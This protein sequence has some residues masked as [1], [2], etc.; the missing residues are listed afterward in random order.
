MGN[1]SRYSIGWCVL[2]RAVPDDGL[3]DVLVYPC[4]SRW[5]L[6]AHAARTFLGRHLRGAGGVIYRQGCCVGVSSPTAFPWRSMAN[7]AES[8][9]PCFESFLRPY[10]AWFHQAPNALPTRAL[11]PGTPTLTRN[12]RSI[13]PVDELL[14]PARRVRLDSPARAYH[15]GAR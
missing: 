2:P 14:V 15:N 4:R 9:P 12:H 3:L 7:L 10:I 5:E 8:F 1:I 13:N 6:T 11:P